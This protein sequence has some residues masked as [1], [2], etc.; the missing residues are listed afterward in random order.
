[1]FNVT[2]KV[3]NLKR[4]VHTFL[5]YMYIFAVFLL[6]VNSSPVLTLEYDACSGG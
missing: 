4:I 3:A 1:M 6:V 2:V 5:P